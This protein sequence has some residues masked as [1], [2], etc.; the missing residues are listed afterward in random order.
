M[1]CSAASLLAA[2]ISCSEW[3]KT[4]PCS[5]RVPTKPAVAVG[6]ASSKVRFANRRRDFNYVERRLSIAKYSCNAAVCH[7][8]AGRL[9]K[10]GKPTSD[11]NLQK[12]GHLDQTV[13]FMSYKHSTEWNLLAE[14]LVPDGLRDRIEVELGKSKLNDGP[15]VLSNKYD[16]AAISR[17]IGPARKNSDVNLTVVEPFHHCSHVFVVDKERPIWLRH[18]TVRN[19]LHRRSKRLGFVKKGRAFAPFADRV[20][21]E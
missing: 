6:P 7:D 17:A 8:I 1:R 19:M 15:C 18:A 21:V 2:E 16:L 10:R 12:R 11:C 13:H 4:G 3:E 9:Q 14:D 20:H 5:A